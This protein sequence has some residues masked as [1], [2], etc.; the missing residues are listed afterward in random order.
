MTKKEFEKLKSLSYTKD[1]TE[2]IDERLLVH[3]CTLLN[4]ASQSDLAI[5]CEETSETHK[6]ILNTFKVVNN[7]LKNISTI[8]MAGKNFHLKVIHPLAKKYI[9]YFDNTDTLHLIYNKKDA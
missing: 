7:Q 8:S 6:E 1:N 2:K 5:L 4:A 3:L 9:L